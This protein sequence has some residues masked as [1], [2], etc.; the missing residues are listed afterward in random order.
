[1]N[2]KEKYKEDYNKL[3]ALGRALYYGFICEFKE[4]ETIIGSHKKLRKN[5]VS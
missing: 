5:S 2:N 3:T 4:H 1:M